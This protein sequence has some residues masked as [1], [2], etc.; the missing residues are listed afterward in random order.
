MKNQ[1]DTAGA[2]IS[3][4]MISNFPLP[5]PPLAE[6]QRLVDKVKVLFALVDEIE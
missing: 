5:L 6:Q 3:L 4:T 2:N 1:V